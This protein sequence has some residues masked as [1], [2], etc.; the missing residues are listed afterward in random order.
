M[1]A[2]GSGSGRLAVLTG[3]SGFL[4]SHLAEALLADGWAVRAA[5]RPAS[6]RRWLAERPID[7]RVADLTSPDDCRALLQGAHTVVHCAGVVTARDEAAYQRGNVETTAQLLKGAA[8]TLPGDGAFI[9]VSSLA[10]H[11]PAALDRPAVES[12]HARPITAYGRS[13]LAAEK[14]VVGQAWPFR[15]AAVRPPALCGPRDRAFVPLIRYAL[16]GWT[17]RLGS[18]LTGLSLLDGRDA[19]GAVA[20]V[21]RTAA[22]RGVFFAD[23]GHRGYSWDGLRAALARAVER[24]VR[25]V[26]VPLWPLRLAGALGWGRMSVL[27]P[28]RLADIDCDGWVC[29][30]SR[31]REATGFGA[32]RDAAASF[33]DALRFYRREGWL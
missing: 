28:D 4:G 20:A 11:G 5:C 17:A 18:R 27:G 9:L 13:K 7:W 3:A 30:G 8:F 1:T 21:A 29:D 31:L 32:E 14:L 25:R 33:A 24:P 16:R 2:A 22:A 19:A 23:D 12:S 15:T 26:T 10:A 6:D